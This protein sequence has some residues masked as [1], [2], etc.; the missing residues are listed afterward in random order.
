MWLKYCIPSTLYAVIFLEAK[1]VLIRFAC[2][3]LEDFN[4]DL[5]TLIFEN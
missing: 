4:N 1:I 2:K 5:T 3:L